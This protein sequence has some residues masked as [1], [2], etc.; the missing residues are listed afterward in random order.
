M[1]NSVFLLVCVLLVF[2]LPVYGFQSYGQEAMEHSVIKPMP[3]SVLIP[4][5][6]KKLK[7]SSYSFY[8]KKGK[9]AERV[10]K[11]GKYWRLRYIIKDAQGRTNRS[12]S[13]MEIAENY[14]AAALEKGGTVL[15]EVKGRL[16]FTLPMQNGGKTWAFVSAGEGSYNI[17]IIEEAGFKKQ[18]TFGAEEMKSALDEEGHIALYG[19]NFDIDKDTLKLGAEKVLIELVKLMK[20]NP[21]LKI[22]IQ[23]H[24]DNTG[25]AGHNLALSKRRAETV[26]NFL[27]IYGIAPSRMVPKGYGMEKPVDT[28]DT[29]EGR[30]MNRR[31]ELIRIDG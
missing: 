27:L 31:V 29:K 12:V 4:A 18:L 6:S 26:K 22:E 5:Q 20:T 2:F 14:K 15:Y 1:K 19:I 9:K 11:K 16:T 28:N 21:G 3:K 10:E 25:S 13:R 8:V 7:F 30:A 23:G 24:T 17:H